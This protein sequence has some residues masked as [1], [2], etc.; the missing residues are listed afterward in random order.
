[1]RR[2]VG[3]EDGCQMLVR[4]R[5]RRSLPFRRRCCVQSQRLQLLML[6]CRCWRR[7]GGAVLAQQLR[8]IRALLFLAQRRC[9]GR[10]LL[11]VKAK[12]RHLPR[13]LMRRTLPEF[14]EGDDTFWPIVIEAWSTLASAEVLVR[15][16]LRRQLRLLGRL[17]EKLLVSL[18]VVDVY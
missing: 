15:G 6:W 14:R 18:D 7:H 12:L 3:Y 11:K 10:R 9:L 1:M 8:L 4:V 2:Q 5:G 16:E 17:A 13:P